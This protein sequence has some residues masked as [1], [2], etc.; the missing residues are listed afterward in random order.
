MKA[1]LLVVALVVLAGTPLTLYFLSTAPTVDLTPKP[2]ALAAQNT[3][4]LQ[5]TSPH[6]VRQVSV[7]LEQGQARSSV[8][9]EE[10][11]DRWMFWKKKL[12]PAVY[13]LNLTAKPEQGFRSGPAKLLVEATANDLAAGTDTKA[14]EVIVNL[15]PP[16]LSVDGEQHYINQGG[17]ELVTFTVTGYATE[18]GVKVG[19]YK[20]RSFPVPG[21]SGENHR[22]CLFAFPWDA[23][24]DTI[25]LVYATNPSGQ[26]VTARFWF[27][28]FPKKFRQ[29][30]LDL[31]DA[32]LEKA[33]N[34][35]EPG[36]AGEKLQ[37]F[38]HINR[39]VRRQNNQTIAEL[40]N[41]TEPRFLWEPPFQQLSNSKVEAFFADVRSYKYEGKKV[42]EQVHLGFDL[43]KVKEA[44]VVASNA[45]KVVYADRLG[46]YG[47]CV[48]L[49]HGFGLQSIY[50]HL[51]RIGVKKGQAVQ[52]GEELGRSGATGLAGGDHLH[53]SMQIDGVQVNPVEWW[54]PHW[55]KDRV[56]S[57]ISTSGQPRPT[58]QANPDEGPKSV[59]HVAKKG[60]RKR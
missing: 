27:K 8:S 50:A 13:S 15:Q 22:F 37:R 40:R 48:V 53:F 52:R 4:N 33:V 20:F 44:P 28:L 46:I 39:E 17:A 47:N 31:S 58:V 43:S 32:F 11:A 3:L 36:G 30:E 25:P 16:R 7:R 42:D 35:I 2:S 18:S 26:E 51:S 45:G 14:Y 60:R 1:I 10:P 59:G 29:R 56:L 6:G 24:A 54:D 55:I 34:D 49:D 12:S 57:K 9:L 41:Q 38:L 19:K 5:V 23:P 21:A